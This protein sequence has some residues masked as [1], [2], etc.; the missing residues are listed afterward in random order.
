[1]MKHPALSTPIVVT[2]LAFGGLALGLLA[3]SAGT[4]LVSTTVTATAGTGTSAVACILSGPAKPSIRTTCSIGP[5][6][7]LTQ[8]LTPAAGPSS[9]AVGSFTNAGNTVTWSL[10]QLS[11]GDVQWQVVANGVSKNGVSKNGTF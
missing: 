2:T 11:N 4:V 6:T 1:M 3:Q 10:Q 7:V 9:G 8:D 5:A